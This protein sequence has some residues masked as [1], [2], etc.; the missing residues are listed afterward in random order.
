MRNAYLTA[1]AAATLVLAAS[2]TLAKGGTWVSVTLQNSQASQVFGINK[3][4]TI[5]G[6]VTD[7]S[8]LVHG[9]IGDFAGDNYKTFDDPGGDT[10]PRAIS[11]KNE[12]T[13]YDPGTLAQWERTAKGKLTAVTKNGTALDQV[14]QGINSFGLFV[15]DYTDTDTLDYVGFFGKNSKWTADIKLTTKNTGYAGRAIDAKGDVGG[16]YYDPTSGL[17][18]GYLLMKGAKSPVLLDYPNAQ[19]TVVEGMNDK[20]IVVGQWEDASSVIHGWIYAIKTKKWTSLDAPGAG[21]TQ[22]WGIN[23]ANVITAS[24]DVAGS[25]VYCMSAKTCPGAAARV[26]N[27]RPTKRQ[28][29]ARP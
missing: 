2:P 14:A 4:N 29:P 26:E 10:E 13:G 7:N 9:F 5:T 19:Y 8:G 1:V 20:S 17:Q 3:S 15:G 25:F 16:W 6:V 21:F 12:T 22:V 11:D 27:I 23:N 24:T 18:R 28:E